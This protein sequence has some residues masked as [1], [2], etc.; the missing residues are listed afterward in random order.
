MLVIVNGTFFPIFS[1]SSDHACVCHRRNKP[2]T[3]LG[4]GIPEE[5]ILFDILHRG[6]L[7]LY[8]FIMEFGHV[9]YTNIHNI[10]LYELPSYS[11]LICSNISSILLF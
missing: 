7:G 11:L 9:M 3:C 1:F 6:L 10:I 5:I 8:F 4:A 2:F